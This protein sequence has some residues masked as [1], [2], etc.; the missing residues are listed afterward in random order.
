MNG[1]D[2]SKLKGTGVVMRLLEM[3]GD[4]Y[5]VDEVIIQPGVKANWLRFLKTKAE[6]R[7]KERGAH[8]EVDG[9]S[10]K[11]KIPTTRSTV[12]EKGEWHRVVN[13]TE[14]PLKLK[15]KLTPS[16]NP[17]RA[18]FRVDD[19]EYRGDEVWFELKTYAG[20]K[21]GRAKYKLHDLSAKKGNVSVLLG[22]KEQ[23]LETSHDNA[24]VVITCIEGSGLLY[25]DGKE[26]TLKK[27]EK[28]KI[29][30]QQRY[31]L[32]N[33][34]KEPFMVNQIHQPQWEPAD[35]WYYYGKDR[36]VHADEVWFEFVVAD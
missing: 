9:V 25:L 36:K 32:E 28:V 33:N 27:D 4:D 35:T 17:Q 14:K 7:A 26:Q 34:T 15:V 11:K 2:L 21:T 16:W 23:S 8:I 19:R 29:A 12:L 24:T 10:R 18:Y 31:Q 3:K 5:S 6:H 1:T 13:Q 30:P 20:D 22:P